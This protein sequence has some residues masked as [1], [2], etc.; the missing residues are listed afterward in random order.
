M[1]NKLKYLLAICLTVTA[2]LSTMAV[3]AEEVTLFDEG[4]VNVYKDSKLSQ[5]NWGDL[6]RHSGYVNGTAWAS[7]W[8]SEGWFEDEGETMVV[9]PRLDKASPENGSNSYIYHKMKNGPLPESSTVIAELDFS[10]G[11]E[12]TSASGEFWY[13]IVFD[14]GGL[15]LCSILGDSQN[16]YTMKFAS[17]T[18]WPF[19]KTVFDR[20]SGSFDIDP[21]TRYTI[22]ITLSPNPDETYQF[23]AELFKGDVKVAGGIIGEWNMVKKDTC[24]T[25]KHVNL[26]AISNKKTNVKEKFLYLHNAKVTAIVPDTRTEAEF[27]PEKGKAAELDGDFYVTFAKQVEDITEADVTI[28]GGAR[29]ES[30]TMSEDGKRA[31]FV[32]SGL[33]TA[34]NYDVKIKGVKVVGAETAFDYDWG[35]STVS[36]LSFGEAYFD[37][38]KQK[39]SFSMDLTNISYDDF[40][41]DMSDEDYINGEK[42]YAEDIDGLQRIDAVTEDGIGYNDYKQTKPVS[43]GFSKRINLGYIDK[44]TMT[45]KVGLKWDTFWAGKWNSVTISLSSSTADDAKLT[46]IGVTSDNYHANA[47]ISFPGHDEWLSSGDSK[48]KDLTAELTLVWNAETESY[49]ANCILKNSDDGT[50]YL[51]KESK[52]VLTA[53]QA[54]ALDTFGCGYYIANG[55]AQKNDGGKFVRFNSFSAECSSVKNIVAGTNNLLIEYKN[56]NENEPFDVTF[57]AVTEKDENGAN[58]ISDVNVIPFTAQTGAA[59]TLT[60]PIEISDPE[61]VKLK[62]Y[63]LNGLDSCMPLMKEV[64]KQ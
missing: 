45:F 38:E 15:L 39:S 10:T 23:S 37:W 52:S 21:E 60:L 20:Y 48:G 22:K 34:T 5:T 27:F 19:T 30:V 31:D 2:V 13:R 16:G 6:T 55:N 51:E 46:L 3:H 24:I 25:P 36:P 1:K 54:A 11:K 40:T 43:K 12:L 42:F 41:A 58:I 8:G 35:F 9:T 61:G 47:R 4:F 50:V 53:E 28:S 17:S 26:C 62:I 63:A 44:G 7:E 33:K 18:S 29:V 57:L 49:D 32:F 64:I 14:E 56:L 59:G